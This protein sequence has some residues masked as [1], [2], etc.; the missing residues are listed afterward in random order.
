VGSL[1]NEQEQRGF[2]RTRGGEVATHDTSRGRTP[3]TL[4][5][6]PAWSSHAVI[7]TGPRRDERTDR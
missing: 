7:R 2:C 1:P 6:I 3:T 5:V 4:F